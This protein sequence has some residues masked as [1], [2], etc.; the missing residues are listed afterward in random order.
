M[1]RLSVQLLR[2]MVQLVEKLGPRLCERLL[3]GPGDD[4]AALVGA[5]GS[6][7]NGPEAGGEDFFNTLG[8]YTKLKG[9]RR[10]VR[11]STRLPRSPGA[12][13]AAG[14]SARGP[15]PSSC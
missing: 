2:I 12:A 13:H 9:V 4:R 5:L 11:P 1:G 15:A 3:S 10:T 8:S 6:V 7:Q 14:S